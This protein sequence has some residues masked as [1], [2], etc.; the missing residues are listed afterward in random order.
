LRNSLGISIFI[1]TTRISNIFEKD[2]FY[3]RH[4][5]ANETQWIDVE[6]GNFNIIKHLRNEKNLIYFQLFQKIVI[7]KYILNIL[8]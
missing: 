1:N 4:P 3:K 5:R 2:N 6:N 8:I 7:I